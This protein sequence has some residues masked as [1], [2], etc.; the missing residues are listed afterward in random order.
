MVRFFR[1]EPS[2]DLKKYRVFASTIHSN[3]CQEV[4]LVAPYCLSN[5][6]IHVLYKYSGFENKVVVFSTVEAVPLIIFLSFSYTTEELMFAFL[7]D[8]FCFCRNM[9]LFH[10]AVWIIPVRIRRFL[11]VFTITFTISQL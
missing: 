2:P 1:W 4:I 11:I 10:P 7:G 8:S 9:K 3:F 6:F 5:V